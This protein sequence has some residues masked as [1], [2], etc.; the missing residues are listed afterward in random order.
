[1]GSFRGR[2][3]GVAGTPGLPSGALLAAGLMLAAG[4]AGSARGDEARDAGSF[5]QTIQPFLRTYCQECHGAAQQKGERRFDRLAAP[6]A[7]DNALVDF[8]DMLDQLNLGEMPPATAKQPPPEAVRRVVAAL[9]A[10]IQDYHARRKPAGRGTVLR[11]LNAREYRNTVRDL[12]KLNMTMFDPA[13][14]FPRDQLD[15]Q[16]DNVG[17]TLVT[18]GHLLDGY[19]DAAERIISKAI[20]SPT[21]PPVE[22]WKFRDNFRQQPEIDQ[23][24]RHTT[25]FRHLTLYDVVGAD[26]H[27]GAYGPILAFR[28]GVPHDGLYEIRL[29]AEA[30]NRQHPYDPEFLGMD[31][32]EPLRLGI[33]A[34]NAVAGPLHKPQPVEPLLAELDLADESRWYTVR[35]WLDRGFTPRFTFRNGLM[36]ARSLWSRILRKYPDMFP[37]PK[38][39]GIVEARYTAIKYGKLPQIHIHEIE[40]EGPLLEQWPTPSQRAVFGDAC[41]EILASRMMSPDQMRRQLADFATRAYRRPATGEE[42]DRLLQLIAARRAAGADA[43]DAWADALQAVLCSP[44][45][46]YLDEPATDG[47]LTPRA[48]AARL[49]YFLWSSLPDAQLA[50]LADTGE[51]MKPSVLAGEAERLLADSRSMALIDGFLDGWLTLR[52]LGSMPPE[53]GQ[54]RAYYQ[55]DLKAAMRQE[56]R[57]FA[58]HLVDENLSVVNFLDSDFTFVNAP[59]ARLYGIEASAGHA[60]QRVTLT[61]RRRGGLLGQA[62]VLTVTAN[63]ID[64]SPVV[65]GVWLLENLLGTPPSPPP[66]DVE[67]LDPDVRGARTIREQLQKHRETTACNDCHRKIDPLG[68]ALENFDAIGRWRTRYDGKQPVD[69]SGQLPNGQ[70]FE[71]VRGLKRVLVDQQQLFVRALTTR[72]LEYALG[73]HVEP[74]D[75]PQIDA[76]VAEFQRRGNGLRDLIK[77]VALSKPFA[78]P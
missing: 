40:I 54:F 3:E 8:Q 7:G 20:G 77:C 11:R 17:E 76:I 31:P 26:K 25:Q 67:P 16:L 49:S 14:A 9:N 2:A 44:A 62:S 66:P 69:A 43:L 19:L 65:R 37:K 29:R 41:E 74:G 72:L 57:L 42:I 38:R 10:Q 50:K 13:E 53:R 58:R 18:S 60:F 28:Q 73:R 48:V 21:R 23:V 59:L 24:H 45:F 12:L 46:L 15:E 47:K 34:G 30:V 6:I 63:G 32:A 35:V 71:D 51:L 27:E 5:E 70:R 68:F 75:R 33:V 36:D 4:L 1:M 78:A 64:T 56:T 22:Q 55:Y 61:D 52:D 39:P